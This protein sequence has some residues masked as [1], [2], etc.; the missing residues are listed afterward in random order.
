[1]TS[2]VRRAARYLWRGRLLFLSSGLTLAVAVAGATAIFAAAYGLLWKPLPY[3]A[4]ARLVAVRESGSRAF[5]GGV[6]PFPLAQLWG[7]SP[8]PFSGLAEWQAEEAN[9]SASGLSRRIRLAEVSPNFLS[10]LGFPIPRGEALGPGGRA[11]LVTPRGVRALGAAAT[12]GRPLTI[13]GH[14]YRVAGILPAGFLFPS[15]RQPAVLVSLPS[16]PPGW[17]AFVQ[18]VAR[19]RPGLGGAAAAKALAEMARSRS[20]QL[21]PSLAPM[22]RAARPQVIPLRDAWTANVRPVLAASLAGVLCLLAVAWAVLASLCLARGSERRRDLALRRALGAPTG[23]M[24]WASA[25]DGVVIAVIGASAGIALAA[26]GFGLVRTAGLPAA[27][28]GFSLA[29]I[30]FGLAALGVSAVL[31][32]LLPALGAVRSDPAAALR[33]GG[34][35]VTG[36]GRR[37]HLLIGFTAAVAVVLCC[38]SLLLTRTVANLLAVRPGFRAGHLLVARLAIPPAEARA[39][40][41][42]EILRRVRALPGVRCAAI[43]GAPPLGGFIGTAPVRTALGAAP[44]RIP[45]T[46]ASPGF[47]RTLGI[48]LRAGHGFPRADQ[49]HGPPPVLVNQAFAAR[50]FGHQDPVGRA[51][52]LGQGRP[53]AMRIVGVMG[54]YRQLGLSHAP[55][56]E[57]VFPYAAMP[58]RLITIVAWTR[59]PPQALA[60][61]LHRLVRAVAPGAPLYSVTTS[62][63]L[64]SRAEAEPRAE[65]ALFGILAALA[66]ALSAFGVFAAAAMEARARRREMALR[67][68]VG[69]SARQVWHAVLWRAAAP[70]G[71]GIAAGLLAAAMLMHYL[72][73]LLFAVRPLDPASFAGAA[74]LM[75]G[76]ALAAG[77]APARRAA[78]VD[79][80]QLLREE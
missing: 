46:F 39:G 67:K 7:A 13:D 17:I 57:I 29:P 21:P 61:A 37:Q 80:A 76:A 53:V 41:P 70:A 4:P 77:V 22:L 64:L 26:V 23:R 47:L 72:A 10:V 49:A 74:G 78:R 63:A 16:F 30:A 40:I 54:N 28:G 50:V 36:P 43:T 32:G 62:R 42:L 56:P 27:P 20:G 34:P 66:L 51:I 79:P 75:L 48:P 35:A 65:M 6:V 1:M 8:Y 33:G 15:A 73:S 25:R 38:A 18:V 69:A 31:V 68:A 71:A 59:I 2:P 12:V 45:F 14:I 19:L 5:S 9:F 24:F 44:Q 3:A 11:A 58:S 52:W 55:R 60:P